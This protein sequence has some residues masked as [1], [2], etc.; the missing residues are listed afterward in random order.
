M[1][2][3]GKR[4]DLQFSRSGERRNFIYALFAAKHSRSTLRKSRPLF[5][6]SYLQ[7]T[8][9]ANVKEDKFTSIDNKQLSD[10]VF[11]I[12]GIIKVEVSVVS[13][14]GGRG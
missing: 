13:R 2:I 12:S 6:G 11:V 7:V 8:W 1:N 4:G 3:F 9:L 5:I 10:E 14:V